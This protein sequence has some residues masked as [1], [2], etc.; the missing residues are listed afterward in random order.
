MK[1]LGLYA[2][3]LSLFT[4]ASVGAEAAEVSGLNKKDFSHYWKV[5]S[6]SPDYKV[7]FSG[8]TAQII[9]PK[10]LT[11][12]RKQKMEGNVTVEFDACVVDEGKPG[13]RLSDLNV[14]WMASDPKHKDIWARSKWRSGIFLN[15]Y[16]M[17]LYYM[18][19]G[20]NHNTT[21]R[22]RRY[23]GDERG[24]TDP[25]FRPAIIKEYTDN[26]HLLKPNHWYH[27]KVTARNGH[28]TYSI[29][30]EQ[31][32]D[33]RDPFPLTSG[34]FGFRTTASRTRI[35]NF[36]YT[37]TPRQPS[38]ITV[39]NISGKTSNTRGATFGVP[40]DQGAVKS[41]TQLTLHSNAD[42]SL[43]QSDCRPLAFWPDGTIKWAALSAPVPAGTDSLTVRINTAVP[44]ANNNG[45]M[46][47]DLGS[48]YLIRSNGTM[49][50]IPKQGN[51]LIDSI[52]RDGIN[53][54]QNV[55]LAASVA[56]T[57]GINSTSC[58]FTGM[59]ERVTIENG[60]S[61]RTTVKIEGKHH[62]GS[63][64]REWLPFTV[65]LYFYDGAPE[66]K[67]LHS[68]IYD[69]DQNRDFINSFGVKYDVPLR[70]ETY[71]R[72]AA[73]STGNSGGVWCE[74]IQPLVGR[75]VVALKGDSD[76]TAMELRQLNGTR[77]P[78]KDEF[79]D[80]S[81]Q[82][83]V[84]MASWDSYRLSQITPDGYTV[85]KRATSTS[86]WIG[87]HGGHRSNGGTFLG[88]SHTGMTA[89]IKDFWESAPSGIQ[90][91]GAR[92]DMA[93]VSLWLWS[94]EAE[95]MDMR[96]YDER[97]HG[98]MT[99]YE[100]VQPGMSTPYGIGRT[101][102]IYLLPNDGYQGKE[103]FASEIVSLAEAPVIVPTPEYLHDRRAF[104]VW[105]LPDRSTP[106]RA[107]VEDRLDL[108]TDFYKNAIEENRWYGFWNYGDVMH[109]YDTSRHEWMYDIGGYAWDNTELGSNLW[110]WYSFLRTGRRD[111]WK[112]A[113]A[114]T[115]HNS[116]V[117]VYHT[118]SNAG[119]G[120]RH[121]VS[122]WGCGA[123]EARISQ[124]AF[125]RF[126][127]YLTADERLG[128]I[129]DDVAD[130]DTMLYTIDPMRLAQP[131]EQYPCTAPAR[132]RIGPDWM[133]YAG[134]WMT[135]WERTGDTRYRDKIITGMKS[136]SA[137]PNGIFTG[138][139]ALGYDP[140]TG[141]ITTECDSTL[142]ATNHLMSIMGGFEVM[143][144]I[145]EMIPDEKWEKIYLDHAD[146]YK[147][148]A[149]NV[150]RNKFRVSR[151]AAYAAWKNNDP[152]KA[153][154]AWHDLMTMSEHKI[155]PAPKLHIIEG[156]QVPATKHELLP[157][158]TNDAALWSLDAIYMQEV[159]PR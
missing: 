18:G 108:Y 60:G 24:V 55:R 90:I 130:N 98:L 35:T 77:L 92:S 19:Y 70:D 22:F 159:I 102:V 156:P 84:D 150:G 41:A 57:P 10:G 46:V 37:A 128:D 91:D 104:G 36:S 14:F 45:S 144:E 52:V 151:L 119:L 149:L 69:G 142:L 121:N 28:I 59:V 87:T 39:R 120:S 29:D 83:L 143:N 131:R 106:D 71:N 97:A 76:K 125:N 138:P 17:S 67:M 5:E 126:L 115:R 42:G 140:A 141:E 157:V 23:D 146:R 74:P 9:S 56:D 100:D 12:W 1:R 103:A 64:G 72:M 48:Q 54:A 88:D 129:M 26:G 134:N 3:L 27:I 145:M 50:Y 148:M 132:L 154:D 109:A 89:L 34:W 136:I 8:D 105:S 113:E 49:T 93:T 80:A 32:V 47:T 137:L 117:D 6:E 20:G 44:K 21:T 31:L 110:L 4:L 133:A 53:V 118:G 107:E 33:Y 30:G 135:R 116:E 147:E 85:R 75:R 38:E 158:S 139:L 25:A 78:G 2:L 79:T 82:H 7:T 11:L 122:H 99:A 43:I 13:D 114:M 61:Q 127:H 86:P 123:K 68:F 111:L 40:F 152:V 96:H 112:M 15:C 65:R 94:P 51:N 124:A 81:Q 16:S 63:T 62:S 153:A 66:I 58:D 155:A 101:S 95:P 73:F